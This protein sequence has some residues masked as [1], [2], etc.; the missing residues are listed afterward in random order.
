MSVYSKP[1]WREQKLLSCALAPAGPQQTPSKPLIK[2]VKLIYLAPAL[3]GTVEPVR[4][5]TDHA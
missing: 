5:E 4:L 2:M 3:V 1:L